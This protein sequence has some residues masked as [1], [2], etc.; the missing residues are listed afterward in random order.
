V[1]RLG[2]NPAKRAFDLPV[3]HLTAA[4]ATRAAQELVKISVL[5]AHTAERING[6]ISMLLGRSSPRAFRCRGST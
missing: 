1:R 5:V 3:E 2:K 4:R 6:A